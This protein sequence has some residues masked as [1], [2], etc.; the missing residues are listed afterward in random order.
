[1]TARRCADCIHCAPWPER[2]ER[3]RKSFNRTP[4]WYPTC[5]CMS[6]SSFIVAVSPEDSPD[7]SASVAF[8]CE[9]FERG[10]RESYIK[11]VGN[12]D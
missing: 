4:Y 3:I 7:N 11:E 12:A 5:A 8:R 10:N 1:M 9:R 6:S 2:V